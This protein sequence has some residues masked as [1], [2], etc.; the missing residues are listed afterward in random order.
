MVP[1]L[2]RY[3]NEPVLFLD[4]DMLCLADIGD[5][6]GLYD[7]EYAVQVVKHDYQPSTG[8]KFLYNVQTHYGKK[9]WSSCMLFNPSR[10]TELTPEYVD[11]TGGMDLHQFRWLE[12]DHEIG[13]LPKGWNYLVGEANQC[14]IAEVKI[15]HY[16][17][18]GP[19][20]AEYDGC[21]FSNAWHL[22]RDDM[23]RCDQKSA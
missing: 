2:C 13:E 5:L 18:G 16:T 14:P 3:T 19:Y 15:A 1:Y 11:K 21:E 12:G 22:E 10:C 8:M 17:L 9:N 23:L 6:F 7:P 4:C 20:F